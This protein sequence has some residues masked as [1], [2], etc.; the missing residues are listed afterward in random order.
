MLPLIHMTEHNG[1]R[2]LMRCAPRGTPSRIISLRLHRCLHHHQGPS[3]LSARA[4]PTPASQTRLVKTRIG[5]IRCATT[6]SSSASLSQDAVALVHSLLQARATPVDSHAPSKDA[7]GAQHASTS[8][9]SPDEDATIPRSRTEIPNAFRRALSAARVRDTRRLLINL[10]TIMNMSS[11]EKRNAVK[12]IPRTTFTEFFRALDPVLVDNDCDPTHGVPITYGMFML[13]QMD[14]IIDDWGV[15]KLYSG[16]LRTLLVMMS[17][18]KEEGLELQH[19]EYMILLRCT[20]AATDVVGART[21]WSDFIHG[22]AR[23]WRGSTAYLEYIK[24][25][26]LTEPLYTGYSKTRRMVTPRALHRSRFLLSRREVER[27]DILRVKA[28]ARQLRFGL[29]KDAKARVE[30]QFR[31]LRCPPSVGR[32]HG[33]LVR[34][35]I[36]MDEE[37][38]CALLVAAG[39]TGSLDYINTNILAEYF[40]I[41]IKGSMAENNLEIRNVPY[42]RHEKTR[43][44]ASFKLRVSPRLLRAVTEAYCSNGEIGTALQ[45]LEFIS[46]TERLTMPSDVWRDLLEWTYIMSTPP[47]SL[48]WESTG[49]HERVPAPQAVE[50]LF[51]AMV[52]PPYNQKPTFEHYHPLIHSLIRGLG[53]TRNHDQAL[54]HMREAIQQ[55]H[56]QCQ[57][58][59]DAVFAYTQALRD[60]VVT[61]ETTFRL[62]RTRF[63]KQKMWFQLRLWCQSMLNEWNPADGPSIHEII[64]E[65]RP[66]LEN[67]ITY[68]TENGYVELFDPTIEKL[69]TVATYEV[70]HTAYYPQDGEDV[71]HKLKQVKIM[72]QSSHSLTQLKS[73]DNPLDLL[74]PERHRFLTLRRP[75]RRWEGRRFAKL[76]S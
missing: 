24:A 39:R 5:D 41:S 51:N 17:M 49:F 60:G 54:V 71:G 74:A 64:D 6:Q 2:A 43:R 73:S 59:E 33:R 58:Y 68:Q 12:T 28:R 50:M 31:L 36:L 27:L 38:V 21:I 10:K 20:G 9:R 13:L 34:K 44:V 47:A 72:I 61:S 56:E 37:L 53:Q 18:L 30:E 57:A 7:R 1:C 25:R 46:R 11:S 4:H 16:L 76:L 19:D 40:R 42:E 14:S 69:N 45:L 65:F 48:A 75:S 63:Q 3:C 32:L 8:E 35:G 67:P 62:E 22:P 52:S 15:R 29:N 23:R 55:Y 66:F 26:F 70:R